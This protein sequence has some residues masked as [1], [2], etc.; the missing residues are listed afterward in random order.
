MTI[1]LTKLSDED[2]LALNAKLNGQGP[3]VATDPMLEHPK[4]TPMVAVGRG[5]MDIAQGGKELFLKMTGSPKA[6]EYSANLAREIETYEKGREDPSNIDWW[7]IGG[8]TAGAIPFTAPVAAVGA[9][10]KLPWFLRGAANLMGMGAVQGAATGAVIPLPA[11]S[12]PENFARDKAV[13]TGVGA[14]AGAIVPPVVGA[15]VK[16]LAPYVAVPASR[17]VDTVRGYLQRGAFTTAT[18]ELTAEGRELVARIGLDPDNLPDEVRQS[19]SGRVAD[20]VAENR[21]LPVDQRL[22]DERMRRVTGEP[23]TAGQRSRDFEQQQLENSMAKNVEVG[24]PLRQRLDSQNAGLIARGKQMVDDLEAEGVDT[25]DV[26]KRAASF[27]KAYD[28]KTQ[29]AVSQLYKAARSKAE[30]SDLGMSPDKFLQTMKD[31]E[32]EFGSETL[33][34]KL[35]LWMK[36]NGLVDDDLN[37][38][39]AGPNSTRGVEVNK[40]EE[41]R[42]M[43]G[44]MRGEGMEARNN[45]RL[46][47]KLLRS[48][49]ED[50]MDWAGEDV[51]QSARS[52]ASARF[53]D[54]EIPGV[55]E[56]IDGDIAPEEFVDKFIRRGA[57]DDIVN[58]RDYTFRSKDPEA[59]ELWDSIKSQVLRE[60][61]DDSVNIGT[62]DSLGNPEFSSTAMQRALNKWGKHG[63]SDRRLEAIFT[64]QERAALKDIL[65]AARDRVPVKGSTNYSG[66][67]ADFWN[68]VDRIINALPMGSAMRMVFRGATEGARAGAK[69]AEATDVVEK[70]LRPPSVSRNEEVTGEI[71]RGITPPSKTF[72]QMAPGE[73]VRQRKE[74]R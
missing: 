63:L 26:G 9:A 3:S 46:V 53:R 35:K 16:A 14:A 5:M 11:G 45:N 52:A 70:A 61:F 32:Y 1:D 50:V 21:G 38:V 37:L 39:S 31:M 51:Y 42:K 49:D 34:P 2:L 47:K 30:A 24:G 67:S 10:T 57:I 8:Q 36:R 73:Y 15:V 54:L 44:S 66:T 60:I 18:G 12:D 7:R 33:L 19:L 62:R 43:L 74:E 58:F 48:L 59:K 4:V 72:L 68:T 23:T 25:Y 71:V 29:N 65:E 6:E 41:L 13:Q 27:V 22:R 69:K 56:L 17:L 28:K 64:K 55:R 20:S 40:V